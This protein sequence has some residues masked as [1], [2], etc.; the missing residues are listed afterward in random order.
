MRLTFLKD[1]GHYRKRA[2]AH[3]LTALQT[4]NSMSEDMESLRERVAAPE[5]QVTNGRIPLH[6]HIESIQTGLHRLQGPGESEREGR[7]GDEKSTL[8]RYRLS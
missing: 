4:L 2:Q 7:R 6:V 1:L 8:D 5:L 3:I